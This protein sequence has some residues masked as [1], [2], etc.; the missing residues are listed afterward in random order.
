MKAAIQDSI[1]TTLHARHNC[2]FSFKSLILISLS[3]KET[4]LSERSGPGTE[5]SHG[6]EDFGYG[7]RASTWTIGMSETPRGRRVCSAVQSTPPKKPLENDLR[8]R[9]LN[10]APSL[11]AQN[12]ASEMWF[13]NLFDGTLPQGMTRSTGK[14][15]SMLEVNCE[16]ERMNM[17]TRPFEVV[18]DGKKESR[19]CGSEL[20][21]RRACLAIH[22]Y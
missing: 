19:E 15:D 8:S 7:Q 22:G 20:R 21:K 3:I 2:S 18:Q 17:H 1:Q 5:C 14:A 11:L 6:E 12:R 16:R 9:Q 13:R 10:R 4:N